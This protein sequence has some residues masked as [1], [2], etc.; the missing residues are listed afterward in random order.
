MIESPIDFLGAV[1]LVESA[2]FKP[3]RVHIRP[4]LAPILFK[5]AVTRAEDSVVKIN[6]AAAELTS[7][8]QDELMLYV[9]GGHYLDLAI[10]KFRCF[11]LSARLR[12][13]R[14]TVVSRS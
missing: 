13:P 14:P 12:P 7:P 4:R 10:A 2:Q 8:D 1:R 5:E 9:M 11:Q 6:L 3:L